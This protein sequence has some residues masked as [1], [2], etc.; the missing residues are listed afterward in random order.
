[1]VLTDAFG[2]ITGYAGIRSENKPFVMG[3]ENI[4]VK[5]VKIDNDMGNIISINIKNTIKNTAGKRR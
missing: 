5:I 1:M 2:I 4:W 3:M